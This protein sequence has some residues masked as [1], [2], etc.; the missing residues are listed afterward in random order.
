MQ[1]CFVV[2]R[3]QQALDQQFMDLDHNLHPA[4]MHIRQTTV[5]RCLDLCQMHIC[6]LL[7]VIRLAGWLKGCNVPLSLA[8]QQCAECC[9]DSHAMV[10]VCRRACS[11]SQSGGP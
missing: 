9:D 3:F 6:R 2:H 1:S 8:C 10:H 7:Y 4:G 11:G 5:I